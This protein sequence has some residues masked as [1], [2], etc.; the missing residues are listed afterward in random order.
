MSQEANN[1][2]VEIAD[3]GP[4]I[5]KHK[6]ET[7][8]NE[9]EQADQPDVT[10]HKRVASSGLGLS[11]S[12]QIIQDHHGKIGCFSHNKTGSVFFFTLPLSTRPAI[13]A[14]DTTAP[15]IYTLA[16][17]DSAQHKTLLTTERHYRQVK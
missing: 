5:E 12:K 16:D 4:G 9:F 1:V 14:T 7:I 2:H 8:F 15:D 10:V 6:A 13:P 11:I 3:S 17:E